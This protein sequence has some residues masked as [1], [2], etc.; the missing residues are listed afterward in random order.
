[1]N[2]SGPERS[3]AAARRNAAA[4]YGRANPRAEGAGGFR[5]SGPAPAHKAAAGSQRERE[6]KPPRTSG[7]APSA[8]WGGEA[9]LGGSPRRGAW[10]AMEAGAGRRVRRQAN[11]PLAGPGLFSAAAHPRSAAR[12][13]PGQ[14]GY[15]QPVPRQGDR[16]APGGTDSGRARRLTRHRR[17]TRGKSLKFCGGVNSRSRRPLRRNSMRRMGRACRSER[18]APAAPGHPWRRAGRFRSRRNRHGKKKPSPGRIRKG[19]RFFCF[20][21]QDEVW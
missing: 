21:K 14:S 10:D 7:S 20:G 17:Q 19:L 11:A 9:S 8:P 1:M 5:Q 13:V 3:P 4:R 15:E 6:K 12:D 2:R 16:P 18:S